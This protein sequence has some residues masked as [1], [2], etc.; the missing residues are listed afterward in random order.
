MPP[1]KQPG[2]SQRVTRPTWK[3]PPSR[4]WLSYKHSLLRR[5]EARARQRARLRQD[6][7]VAPDG[8]RPGQ[9]RLDDVG[10]GVGAASY[11][12]PLPTGEPPFGRGCETGAAVDFRRADGENMQVISRWG[13]AEQPGLV[14]VGFPNP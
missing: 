13:P 12:F 9:D 6:V 1:C 5:V 8:L 4:R 2:I 3:H 7:Q 11:V 10:L 14:P